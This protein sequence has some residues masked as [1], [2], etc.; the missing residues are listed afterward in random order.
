MYVQIYQLRMRIELNEDKKREI[1]EE[2][3]REEGIVKK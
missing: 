2:F 1:T 3:K